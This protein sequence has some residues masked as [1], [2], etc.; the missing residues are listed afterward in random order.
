MPRF[1]SLR[2]FL[3]CQNR[4]IQLYSSHLNRTR[5]FG[6]FETTKW[7]KLKHG[8]FCRRIQTRGHFPNLSVT[9]TWS[10]GNSKS[11]FI[12]HGN[13]LMSTLQRL[14]S[15]HNPQN[16]TYQHCQVFSDYVRRIFAQNSICGMILPMT[17]RPRFKSINP[18]KSLGHLVDIQSSGGTWSGTGAASERESK[19]FTVLAELSSEEVVKTRCANCN[20]FCLLSV[21]NLFKGLGA[22]GTT[23]K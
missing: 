13:K 23:A 2:L 10:S 20:N 21:S 8:P 4:Y 12:G 9:L 22:W 11:V 14:F 5:F 15:R 1:S 6:N 18:S 3:R 19:Y 16:P 7:S 17:L